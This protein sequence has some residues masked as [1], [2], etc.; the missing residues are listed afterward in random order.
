M[1]GVWFVCLYTYNTNMNI[2]V[3]SNIYV[4]YLRLWSNYDCQL[5]EL[6][7]CIYVDYAVNVERLLS[8]TRLICVYPAS[9]HRLTLLK[10]FRSKEPWHFVRAVK[11]KVLYVLFTSVKI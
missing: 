8:P 11:G 10:G 5:N 3:L 7:C 6:G 2:I 4:T 1:Y 9:G